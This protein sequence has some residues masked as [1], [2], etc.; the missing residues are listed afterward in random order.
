MASVEYRDIIDKIGALARELDALSEEEGSQQAYDLADEL[1]E[2]VD[3]LR[4]L[5]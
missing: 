2:M 5:Q 4:S 3:E 1:R